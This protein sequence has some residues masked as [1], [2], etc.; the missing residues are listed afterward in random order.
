MPGTARSAAQL[1]SP[2]V[3]MPYDES[4][5]NLAGPILC[6]LAALMQN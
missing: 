3:D 1:T 4:A 6:V 2:A 5:T